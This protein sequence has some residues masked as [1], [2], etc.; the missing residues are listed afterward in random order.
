MKKLFF[1]ILFILLPLLP[2]TN[3]AQ[4]ISASTLSAIS[5]A[6]SSVPVNDAQVRTDL[7]LFVQKE[8]GTG[9]SQ[10]DAIKKTANGIGNVIKDINI[11][12][13][14]I[15]LPN[16]PIPKIG[17]IDIGSW[18][19]GIG[20]VFNSLKKAVPTPAWDTLTITL[21]RLATDKIFDDMTD[22]VNR[23]FDGNPA[24]ALNLNDWLKKSGDAV[25]GQALNEITNGFACQ[26]FRLEIKA[27]I[28]RDFGV[29]NRGRY[30]QN[31]CTLSDIEGNIDEFLGGDFK[32]GGL[33]AWFKIT[34]VD[35]NNPYGEYMLAVNNISVNIAGARNVELSRLN[36][37]AGFLGTRKCVDYSPMRNPAVSDTQL[38]QCVDYEMKMMAA[39]NRGN[40][41][42][43]KKVCQDRLSYYVD[44]TTKCLNWQETTPG[45]LLA[46]QVSKVTGTAVDQVNLA[47]RFDEFLG[48]VV[49]QLTNRVFSSRGFITNTGSAPYKPEPITGGVDY[50]GGGSSGSVGDC[51][52]DT[53]TAVVGDTV[54]WSVDFSGSDT[55][56]PQFNWIGDGF[57]SGTTTSDSSLAVTYTTPGNA[58]KMSVS[59]T[60][61]EP[62]L[63]TFDS[64]TQ[65]YATVNTVTKNLDCAQTV[66]VLKYK[67]IVA[68]CA[69]DRQ[70]AIVGKDIVVYTLTVDGGSGTLYDVN[71]EGDQYEVVW[72]VVSSKGFMFMKPDGTFTAYR[73]N[74]PVIYSKAG[75]KNI[76]KFGI[77]YIRKQEVGVKARVLDADQTLDQLTDID[78]TPNGKVIVDD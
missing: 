18:A 29:S 11:K 74:S 32:Q 39:G 38:N 1:I 13:P 3:R 33:P 72:P 30:F 68:S 24:F 54:T 14:K 41:D 23:G 20:N 77:I 44:D 16:L 49:N 50:G 61:Q 58:K 48:A 52:V 42:V 7:H 64:T 71:V 56:T 43:A 26:P 66:N 45:H 78:C 15:N 46:E 60:Y 21:V 65:T 25:L 6:L 53:T 27:A 67:P 70:R 9:G 62:D 28:T 12:L 37:S 4:A 17:G 36:W 69:P 10:Q 34:Q 55:N 57:E 8:I 76:I 51:S 31:S 35:E 63:T 59:V 40:A 47:N 2:A 19:K 75:T 73:N 22:W 5:D